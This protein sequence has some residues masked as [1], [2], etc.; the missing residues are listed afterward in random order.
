ML[1]IALVGKPNVGK[2][3]L[4][5]RIFGKRKAI[6]GDEPGVT[7]DRN[8]AIGT[9][10][11]NE[12]TIIDTGGLTNKKLSF[13]ENIEQQV[14]YAVE[15]AD[16]ILFIV[17]AKEGVNVEDYYA[18]KVIKKLKPK[19]VIT[20]V[21]KADAGDQDE[22]K[23]YSIGFGKPFFVSAA[24]SYGVGDLLDYVIKTFKS[25]K[26]KEE[27]DESFK[28]CIIGRTNVGKST[29]LNTILGEERSIASPIEH[30]TRDS[31]D[32]D[33]SYHQDKFTI[34]DTA[35]IRRKGKIKDNIEKFAILRTQE[36]VE[37]SDL[38]ILVLDGSEEFN[39]QD[40]VIG[41]IAFKANIPTIICVNK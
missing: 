31:I 3:T 29:L 26:V 9:W 5:N 28:F 4:F 34:I 21:N 8:T 14:G 24:H 11:D 30:T 15:Q 1:K 37:R 19:N 32:V 13:R 16:V 35:G 23:Y 39:E 40:E 20:V 27:K 41:G 33:F 25:S 2:S 18:A 36:A 6:V 7:R 38:I 10:L 12:F 22:K 17:S